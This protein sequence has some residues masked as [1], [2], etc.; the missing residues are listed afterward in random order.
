MR[1]F[2]KIT[3]IVVFLLMYSH[4]EA[5]FLKKLGDRVSEAVENT[6]INKSSDKAAHET[7]ESMD[8]VFSISE[9]SDRK[10]KKDRSKPDRRRA[11]SSSPSPDKTYAFTHR[12]KMKI[13]SD[14]LTKS[15]DYYYNPHKSYIG[16]KMA[17]NGSNIFM[18]FDYKQNVVFNFISSAN[19]K[20]FSG[21]ALNVDDLPE[22][23]S[24]DFS[25]YTITDLSSKTILGYQCKGKKIEN[26]ESIFIMYY[27]TEISGLNFQK[28]FSQSK[29]KKLPPESE[30][31][32]KA[33]GNGLILYIKSIDKTKENQSIVMKCI[34]LDKQDF[35]F[36]TSG[37]GH[38]GR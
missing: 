27:T 24:Q 2:I 33:V 38:F 30:K 26:E 28:I 7:S 17:Q 23:N 9:K 19:M 3:S 10:N 4:A 22:Q 5:Q 16:M 15:F 25:D 29:K 36:N 20:I 37:Y 11:T 12:Y 14:D 34:G 35:S 8:N 1:N 31:L 21:M 32:L 18:I 6:V 13:I